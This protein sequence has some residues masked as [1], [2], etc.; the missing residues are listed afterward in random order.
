MVSVRAGLTVFIWCE[1]EQD[2]WELHAE[3]LIQ[4]LV[5]TVSGW[6]AG[7]SGGHLEL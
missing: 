3:R 2:S 1:V 7:V 5:E 6:V 4:M